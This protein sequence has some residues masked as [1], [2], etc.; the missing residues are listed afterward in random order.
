M[1]SDS[2]AQFAGEGAAY[3]AAVAGAA[4]LPGENPGQPNGAEED[5]L[6]RGPARVVCRGR[7]GPGRRSAHADQRAVQTAEAI[8]GRR[9]ELAWGRPFCPEATLEY[10]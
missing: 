10:R 7:D 8:L 9:D 1:C 4:Q 5:P 6:E 3:R 2:R